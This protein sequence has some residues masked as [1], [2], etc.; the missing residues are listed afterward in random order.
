MKIF[1]V[2]RWNDFGQK[3]NTSYKD[4]YELKKACFKKIDLKTEQFKYQWD[5]NLA[6]TRDFR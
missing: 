3:K 5:D 6:G 4:S 1:N 2:K